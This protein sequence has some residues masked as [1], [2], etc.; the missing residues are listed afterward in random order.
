VLDLLALTKGAVGPRRVR[1]SLPR[2]IRLENRDDRLGEQWTS[3]QGFVGASGGVGLVGG[4]AGVAGVGRLEALAGK[5]S[6]RSL[7]L[8]KTLAQSSLPHARQ[9]EG[10]RRP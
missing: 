7:S 4:V 5:T 3:W 8:S 1:I 10:W 6:S 9:Q 2:P